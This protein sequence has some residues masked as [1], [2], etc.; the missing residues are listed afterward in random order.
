MGARAAFWAVSVTGLK[1]GPMWILTRAA[2]SCMDET[3]M[4]RWTPARLA[5]ACRL[6]VRSLETHL[7]RLSK[8]GLLSQADEGF[9]VSGWVCSE[10]FSEKFSENFSER[11]ER[12]KE[13]KEIGVE[14]YEQKSCDQTETALREKAERIHW[15]LRID[16]ERYRAPEPP[17]V[18]EILE[19]LRKG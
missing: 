17:S 12:T 7:P 14:V 1:S 15:G 6:T 3:G 19:K 4:L 10:N 9:R 8:L 16:Q 13:K 18:D 11:K 5:A 2:L